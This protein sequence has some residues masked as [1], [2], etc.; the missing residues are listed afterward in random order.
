[1]QSLRLQLL[2]E[3]LDVGT[4]Q[5]FESIEAQTGVLH[6][7]GT[8]NLSSCLLALLDGNLID[9]TWRS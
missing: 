9:V 1:M 7:D 4:G 2:Q 8:I 6:Q 5:A 3:P